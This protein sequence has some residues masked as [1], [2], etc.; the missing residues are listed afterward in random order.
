MMTKRHGIQIL[1]YLQKLHC[2]LAPITLLCIWELLLN[3]FSGGLQRIW[4]WCHGTI[5]EMWLQFSALF[6]H[7]DQEWGDGE[8]KIYCKV[9]E[10]YHRIDFL[11]LFEAFYP[12][13][14]CLD[15]SVFWKWFAIAFFLGLRNTNWLKATQ[16][17]Y[18]GLEYASPDF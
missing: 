3:I 12:S 2:N 18:A 10:T 17:P 15:K 14:M 16:L 7:L 4:L 9:K 13:G 5:K 11:C 1:K 8:I 6:H